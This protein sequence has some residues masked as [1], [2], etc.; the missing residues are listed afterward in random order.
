MHFPCSTVSFLYDKGASVYAFTWERKRRKIRNRISEHYQN[1]LTTNLSSHYNTKLRELQI[2]MGMS[3]NQQ[4]TDIYL[5]RRD[6]NLRERRGEQIQNLLLF[7]PHWQLTFAVQTRF[8]EYADEINYL[9]WLWAVFVGESGAALGRWW[10]DWSRR[11]AWY[12]SGELIS[13]MMYSRVRQTSPR[14]HPQH[15]GWMQKNKTRHFELSVSLALGLCHGLVGWKQ[16]IFSSVWRMKA[17]SLKFI[18]L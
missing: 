18:F 7:S 1:N 8:V 13:A 12:S 10:S 4:T 3:F 5:M 9:G 16:E 6:S 2:N 14:A 17:F 11:F 15:N